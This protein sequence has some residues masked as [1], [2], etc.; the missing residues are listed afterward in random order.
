MDFY[1]VEIDAELFNKAKARATSLPGYRAN[2]KKHLQDQDGELQAKIEGSIGEL[3]FEKW[4]N[5]NSI[6]YM[7]ARKNYSH[8][9]FLGGTASRIEVKTK[10]R[11]VEPPKP[12]YECSVSNYILET[13][14]AGIYAFVSL[15]HNDTLEL[16]ADKYTNGYFVGVMSGKK[17]KGPDF[18]RK[19]IFNKHNEKVEE[20]KK[21]V[22]YYNNYLRDPKRPQ[23]P[24]KTGGSSNKGGRERGPSDQ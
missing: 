17:F 7:D 16:S 13:Q 11:T 15:T 8:D 3:I 23:L 6:A 18:V 20:V 22:Q 24:E 12:H 19:H 1:K 10:L 5:D 2:F 9:Y 4:L 14:S 21:E